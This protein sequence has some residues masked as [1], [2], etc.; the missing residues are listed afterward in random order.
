MHGVIAYPALDIEVVDADGTRW[1]DGVEGLTSQEDLERNV[2]N[3]ML[4][5]LITPTATLIRQSWRVLRTPTDMVEFQA[6]PTPP[7]RPIPTSFW[8]D[9]NQWVARHLP[10]LYAPH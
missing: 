7:Y 6:P 10:R 9:Y 2:R 3:R 1:V 8:C 4:G 5:L